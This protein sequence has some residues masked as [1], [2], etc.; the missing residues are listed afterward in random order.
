MDNSAISSSNFS[1]QG[2]HV[3]A[4]V[5][6]PESSEEDE[7]EQEDEEDDEDEDDEGEGVKARRRLGAAGHMAVKTAA[8]AMA[9]GIGSLSDPAE[10]QASVY[11]RGRRLYLPQG[12]RL[13][14]AVNDS[15][16]V[17]L[18]FALP[19]LHPQYGAKAEAYLG[20]LVGHEGPGLLLSLLKARGWATEVCAGCEEEGH[21]ASSACNLCSITLT[22]TEAGLMAGPGGGPGAGDCRL[23]LPAAAEEGWWGGASS[24]TGP[25]NLPHCPP[26]AGPQEWVWQELKFLFQ[27]EEEEAMDCV[28]SLAGPL[29]L[30]AAQ[31][32]LCHEFLPNDF[33]P[34]LVAG[35]E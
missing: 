22:L 11:L 25:P 28:R 35:G 17:S 21:A 34:Q 31:H 1:T 20:H 5:V 29:H 23:R 33:V 14:P 18:T 26:P 8:A 16:E 13:M 10:L 19:C 7:G 3:V 6:A 24:M 15:H 9:V 2:A 27:L 4:D 30:V 12:R 32:A